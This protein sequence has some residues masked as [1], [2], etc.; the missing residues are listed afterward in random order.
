[1]LLMAVLMAG[2][3]GASNDGRRPSGLGILFAYGLWLTLVPGDATRW[4]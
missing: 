3:D 2:G 1:M 4:T